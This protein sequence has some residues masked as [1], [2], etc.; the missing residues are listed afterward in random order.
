MWV[1]GL[2]SYL[3][4]PTSDADVLKKRKVNINTCTKRELIKKI[5]GMTSQKAEEIVKGRPYS[6]IYELVTKKVLTKKELSRIRDF[7]TAKG[8]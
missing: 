8:P 1:A 2:M 4:E 6:N 3:D 5:P 7:I